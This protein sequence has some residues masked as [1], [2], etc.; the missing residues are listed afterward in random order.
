MC[1]NRFLRGIVVHAIDDEAA[2]F[3]RKHGF[4]DCPLGERALILPIEIARALI[5]QAAS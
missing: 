4:L 1:L 2:D 5:S 3:Y